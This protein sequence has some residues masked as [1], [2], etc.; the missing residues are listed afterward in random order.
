MDAV[1]R[2]RG[3]DAWVAANGAGHGVDAA[4]CS[5]DAVLLF[6]VTNGTPGREDVQVFLRA[7]AGFKEDAPGVPVRGVYVAAAP[8]DRRSREIRSPSNDTATPSLETKA[9]RGPA[10]KT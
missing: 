10:R 9:G 7:L 5:R 8:A 2:N 3:C 4:A 1:L 6:R